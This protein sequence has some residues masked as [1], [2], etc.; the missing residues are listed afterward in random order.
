[1]DETRSHD[2]A[3]PRLRT[4]GARVAALLLVLLSGAFSLHAT[5]IQYVFVTSTGA[6]SPQQAMAI[7]TIGPD[8]DRM[9]L[10]MLNL[11]TNPESADSLI[12]GISFTTDGDSTPELDPVNKPKATSII[13]TEEHGLIVETSPQLDNTWHI[14]PLTTT[15]VNVKF[16]QI[17]DT[18]QPLA[19][20]TS[21]GDDIFDPN[22]ARPA[23]LLIGGPQ[24][25]GSYYEYTAKKGSVVGNAPHNPFILASGEN[26]TTGP[27]AGVLTI[28]EWHFLLPGKGTTKISNVWFQFGTAAAINLQGKPKD[29]PPPP[30][31]VPEPGTFV[32]M[33]APLAIV[34]GVA[35]YKRKS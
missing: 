34:I 35:R 8:N 18:V 16:C 2:G 12:A 9:T 22:L 1:M 28:P 24:T 26:Y 23:G 10:Q 17:C 3:C 31:A 11:K 33:T 19:R 30:G 7:F 14:V 4:A 13:I 29:P 32:F 25:S 27:L 15:P 21:G 6:D 5:A 20:A